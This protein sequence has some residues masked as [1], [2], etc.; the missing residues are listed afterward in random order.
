MRNKT[1]ITEERII[2]AGFGGQGIMFLGKLL[3][4]SAMR[5]NKQVTWMPSYGAEVRGGTA[6]SMVII[7]DSPIPSPVVYKPTTCIIMNKPSFIKFKD[8]AEKGGLLLV[9][10]SLVRDDVDRK[11]IKVVKIPATDIAIQ[12]GNAKIANMVMYGAYLRARKMVRLETAVASLKEIFPAGEKKL[13][14]LNE[15]AIKKGWE[16]ADAGR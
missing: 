11:D 5:E 7:S 12:I 15:C 2:S 3:S 4:F 6:Y 16:A 14:E 13:L 9:N 8:I 10:S 1:K